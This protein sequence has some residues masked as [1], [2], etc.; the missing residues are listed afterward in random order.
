MRYDWPGN[1]RELRHAL[2]HACI[3]CPGGQVGM[4]HMRRD[5][6]D[7]LHGSD[8]VAQTASTSPQPIYGAAA[9]PAPSRRRVDRQAVV[10]ALARAG[11]NKA[12]A[13]RQLGIHRATLYRKLAAEPDAPNDA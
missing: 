7:Q 5:F 3:L 6:M 8:A 11:G 4:E 13:A 1:V 2:E 10:E 12:M 9:V